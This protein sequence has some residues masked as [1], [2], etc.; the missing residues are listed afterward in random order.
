MYVL[1]KGMELDKSSPEAKAYLL[2]MMEQLEN[3]HLYLCLDFSLSQ[4]RIYSQL[5][6]GYFIFT[7]KYGAGNYNVCVF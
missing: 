6:L 7:G 1:Q 2:Y 4:I 5:H 3:V